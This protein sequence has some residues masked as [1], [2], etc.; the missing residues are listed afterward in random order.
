MK[1]GLICARNARSS[2][3]IARVRSRFRSASWI[4]PDTQFATSSVARTSPAEVR[5]PY[6]DSTATTVSPVTIGA[7]TALR[8]EH[9]GPPGGQ[10]LP[11]ESE[12][13]RAVV[14][15]VRTADALP[16]EH[17]GGVADRDRLGAEQVAQMPAGPAGRG[18][19]EALAQARR[20]E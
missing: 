3:S 18:G 9:G 17:A 15:L 14:A 8:T 2:A 12:R 10:G 7:T 20:G 19:G 11:G 1:C 13:V 5:G 16:G 6:A 4:C